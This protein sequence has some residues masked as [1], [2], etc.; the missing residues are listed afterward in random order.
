MLAWRMKRRYAEVPSLAIVH[1]LPVEM[2]PPVMNIARHFAGTGR[3]KVTV[4][5]TSTPPARRAFS[6]SRVKMV[7]S[8][9]PTAGGWWKRFTAYVSYHCGTSLRL[10]FDRPDIILY[11]ETHSSF[12][13]LLSSYLRREVPLFIH[14]HEYTAPEDLKQTGMRL[15]RVFHRL[16]KRRLF[17]KAAWISHTNKERLELFLADNPGVDRR[18]AKVLP[19][20]PPSHWFGLSND[21]WTHHAP[22]PLRMIYVGSLSARDTYIIEFLDWLARQPAGSVTLDIFAYNTDSET[23]QLLSGAQSPAMHFF[24]G[25]VE[26]DDLPRVLRAYHTGVI[27]YKAKTLNYR[28]N[29]S[30]KLFEYMACGLD[31]LYP[32]RMLG[33]RTYARADVAPRVLEMDLEA[34][35]TLDLLSL[36]QPQPPKHAVPFCTAE[37]VLDEIEQAMLQR[38]RGLPTI[39]ATRAG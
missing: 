29:A 17:P 32:R 8:A 39:P 19:N 31:V 12:P 14:Y 13:I 4:Y 26:Y 37:E 24:D 7:R 18:I 6:H 10:L 38:V 11:I 23:R 27:L 33:V 30:N 25:G 3:W 9:L 22:P 28:H 20:L 16:E 21:A 36:I 5:S 1:W 34:E 2:Y 15:A 35:D